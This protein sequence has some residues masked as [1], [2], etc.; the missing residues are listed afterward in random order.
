M[1]VNWLGQ[2]AQTA[3]TASSRRVIEVLRWLLNSQETTNHTYG[4]SE[5]SKKYLA[6][7]VAVVTGVTVDAA[8]EY[9]REAEAD[10]DIAD[11]LL[12][13]RAKV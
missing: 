3:L 4:L 9:I 7:T 12:A 10:Q 13:A 1:R 2:R 5:T 6:H 8:A 11:H